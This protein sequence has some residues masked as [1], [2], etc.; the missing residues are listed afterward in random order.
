M[1]MYWKNLLPVCL[2]IGLQSCGNADRNGKDEAA[3]QMTDSLSDTAKSAQVRTADANRGDGKVFALSAAAGG[4]M[5]VEAANL[6]LKKSKNKT[7]KDFAA[8]MLKDHGMANKELEKIALGKGLDLPQTLPGDLAAY[9]KEM[10]TLAERAFDVQYMRMMIDDHQKTVSL[11]TD[12]IRL[13]DPEF[14]AF[15]IKTLPVIREHHKMAV[16]IGKSL[17]ITNANSGDDVLGV[18]PTRVENN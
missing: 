4:M 17:N 13:T 11:F 9:L 18:S 15:A 8:R 6:A 3:T 5:E 2:L 16:E 1:K 7:V 12:G 10:N 14:K